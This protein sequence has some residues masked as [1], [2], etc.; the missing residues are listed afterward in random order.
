[1]FSVTECVTEVSRQI[2]GSFIFGELWSEVLYDYGFLNSQVR[3]YIREK[4]WIP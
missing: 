4:E 3:W 1:M 2:S